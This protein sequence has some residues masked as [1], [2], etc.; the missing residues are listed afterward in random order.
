MKILNELLSHECYMICP[1]HPPRFHQ[2]NK[3][4]LGKQTMKLLVTQHLLTLITLQLLCQ[5]IL[6][7]TLST[8]IL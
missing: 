3:I 5:H 2:S 7:S 1:S 6:L 8:K 4:W